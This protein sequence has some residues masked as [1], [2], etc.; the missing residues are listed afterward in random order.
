LNESF[1]ID[2]L[3]N[4]LVTTAVTKRSVIKHSRLYGQITNV[5]RNFKNGLRLSLILDD[6]S[7]VEAV[8]SNDER[9]VRFIRLTNDELAAREND[10]VINANWR[11]RYNNM[12]I[13][14]DLHGN[15]GK[16]WSYGKL[17]YNDGFQVYEKGNDARM[18]FN[19]YGNSQILFSNDAKNAVNSYK[20]EF[21]WQL[22][23]NRI[24][25]AYDILPAISACY[26]GF[27]M[28]GDTAI[29][30]YLPSLGQM[31][32]IRD[33]IVPINDLLQLL[34]IH[35]IPINQGIWWTS[36]FFCDN[37]AWTIGPDEIAR[38]TMFTKAQV[39]PLYKIEN[40]S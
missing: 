15:K 16:R 19:G 23:E 30:G 38:L 29:T 39:L 33:N 12:H 14:V 27:E 8:D 7:E 40:L 2:D 32:I 5:A 36:S 11:R 13:D 20:K 25:D 9:I 35:P 18:D 17:T 10:I 34:G 26:N 6:C 21:L 24:N 22:D 31:L 37:T 1:D 3:G 4:E 28:L